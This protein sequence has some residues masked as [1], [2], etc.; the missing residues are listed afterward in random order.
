MWIFC[1]TKPHAL[2][3]GLDRN[4]CLYL[5]QC[6][7]VLPASNNI[8]LMQGALVTINTRSLPHQHP[9]LHHLHLP[10]ILSCQPADQPEDV[11]HGVEGARTKD[12]CPSGDQ[13]RVRA[14]GD[15]LTALPRNTSFCPV[16]EPGLS[17]SPPR[18][19]PALQLGHGDTSAGWRCCRWSARRG[20]PRSCPS[21]RGKEKA[22]HHRE[23]E[24][25]FG[26]KL[27]CIV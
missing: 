14:C 11:R 20:G 9:C 15:Q 7:Q 24:R 4:G 1:Q 5:H 23:W 27:I 6:Q 19:T 2:K 25:I 26:F 12:N 17:Q 13:C 8:F 18:E 21:D 10:R 16:T 3:A 22:E